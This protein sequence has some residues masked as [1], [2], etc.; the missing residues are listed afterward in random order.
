MGQVTLQIMTTKLMMKL[1]WR[2]NS[3]RK[4]EKGLIIHTTR[5]IALDTMGIHINIFLISLQKP[6]LWVLIGRALLVL[7]G[8]ALPMSTK[9]M[10]FFL[11]NKKIT[12]QIQYITVLHLTKSSISQ[13]GHGSQIF[14]KHKI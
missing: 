5:Y 3:A 12:L 6:T 8:R 10:F 9:N 13:I 4:N 1:K 7:I 11:R 14:L 2:H